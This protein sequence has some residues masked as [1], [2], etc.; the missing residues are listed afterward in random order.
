[1]VGYGLD[2]MERYRN[3]PYIGVLRNDLIKPSA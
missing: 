2:Y 1:V 3:L